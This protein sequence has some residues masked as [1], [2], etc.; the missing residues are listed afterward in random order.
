MGLVDTFNTVTDKIKNIQEDA[1]Y[2]GIDAAGY[3]LPV[4]GQI[5]WVV[6]YDPANPQNHDETAFH[7]HFGSGVA[8]WILAGS[9]AAYDD[10]KK[11][12]EKVKV[13]GGKIIK[14]ID[15]GADDAGDVLDWL[16]WLL[17]LSAWEI[18]AML[19]GVLVFGLFLFYLFYKFV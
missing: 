13:I 19:G 14:I 11:I 4:V 18:G 1:L 15:K 8:G 16:D 2:N 6:G 10:S 3:V 7:K 12:F 9:D 17:S 5:E